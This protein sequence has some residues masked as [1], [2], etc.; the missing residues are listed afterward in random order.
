M[1]VTN[2]S[3]GPG[4]VEE[5]TSLEETSKATIVHGTFQKE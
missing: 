4:E 5:K 2:I 1:K 3:C